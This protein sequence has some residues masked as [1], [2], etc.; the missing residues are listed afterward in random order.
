MAK[1]NDLNHEYMAAIK[2]ASKISK[3]K[4]KAKRRAA[5]NQWAEEMRRVLAHA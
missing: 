1:T 2:A 3:A 4:T 5:V